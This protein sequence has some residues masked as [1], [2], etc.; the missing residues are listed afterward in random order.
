MLFVGLPIFGLVEYQFKPH[1]LTWACKHLMA[2]WL[3]SSYQ[4]LK[5]YHRGPH[6]PLIFNIFFF[7][8]NYFSL[9]N[10]SPYN[11]NY[12]NIFPHFYLF[13]SPLLYTLTL[14]YPHPFIF[15]FSFYFDS[16]SPYIIYYKNLIFSI[17]F[18]PYFVHPKR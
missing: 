6:H 4:L 11:Y 12:S 1:F 15:L 5:P 7:F 14:Q 9:I 8:F 10:F 18:N 13:I 17:P 2:S 3:M 16:S